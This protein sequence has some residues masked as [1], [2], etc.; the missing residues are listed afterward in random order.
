MHGVFL[1]R[2]LYVTYLDHIYK[3]CIKGVYIVVFLQSQLG[4][5]FIIF[6][7]ITKVNM[8]DEMLNIEATAQ[9]VPVAFLT[10]SVRF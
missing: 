4:P 5:Y 1:Y 9:V 3:C 10:H 6:W 8:Q 2:S 7:A